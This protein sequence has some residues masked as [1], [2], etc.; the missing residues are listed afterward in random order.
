MLAL[1]LRQVEGELRRRARSNARG[2]LRGA[3][4]GL[5]D[6]LL[7]GRLR[8]SCRFLFVSDAIDWLD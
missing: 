7:A 4:R 5:G 2:N 6:L 1:E 8:G 3:L